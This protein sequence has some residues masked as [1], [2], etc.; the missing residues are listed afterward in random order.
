MFTSYK[1]KT[2]VKYHPLQVCFLIGLL[3]HLMTQLVPSV[4]KKR[5]EK[6]KGLTEKDGLKYIKLQ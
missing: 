2:L 1:T 5:S 4:V 6:K 3:V